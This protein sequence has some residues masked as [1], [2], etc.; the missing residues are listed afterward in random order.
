MLAVVRCGTYKMHFDAT[1]HQLYDLEK[2]PHEDRP[3]DVEIDPALQ[4]LAV[5]PLQPSLLCTF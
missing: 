3:L 1:P 4:V 2:D 5:H